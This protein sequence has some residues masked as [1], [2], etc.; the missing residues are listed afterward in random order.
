L[1]FGFYLIWCNIYILIEHVYIL[2][3]ITF[4]DKYFTKNW[5]YWDMISHWVGGFHCFEG[6]GCLH[7][8]ELRSIEGEGNVVSHHRRCNAWLCCCEDLQTGCLLTVL[9][10]SVQRKM[11]TNGQFC[12]TA[13]TVSVVRNNF[14]LHFVN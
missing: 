10:S 4:K 13:N 3:H 12:Y 8:Q 14:C 7:L 11:N 9:R 6:M 5:F 2:Y 1:P